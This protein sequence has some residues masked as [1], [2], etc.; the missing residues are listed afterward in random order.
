[1]KIYSYCVIAFI[2]FINASAS[3]EE[4]YR[5]DHYYRPSLTS[6][7][8][9][10][11]LGGMSYVVFETSYKSFEN[12]NILGHA[13]CDLGL[14]VGYKMILDGT[15]EL[16]HWGYHRFQNQRYRTDNLKKLTLH[17]KR[18]SEDIRPLKIQYQ[19]EFT[20]NKTIN[21]TR[22]LTSLPFVLNFLAQSL[23][24][25]Y[26]FMKYGSSLEQFIIDNPS[27]ELTFAGHHPILLHSFTC[28]NIL[29]VAYNLHELYKSYKQEEIQQGDRPFMG[30]MSGL[31]KIFA[32][33]QVFDYYP[34][35][36]ILTLLDPATS[37]IYTVTTGSAFGEYIH[38]TLVFYGTYQFCSN[39]FEMVK[40]AKNFI[41]G[42][43]NILIEDMQPSI[44]STSLQTPQR[45]TTRTNRL[46]RKSRQKLPPPSEE[47]YHT[48]PLEITPLGQTPSDNP[49]LKT[50]KKTRNPADPSKINLYKNPVKE[51]QAPDI[52]NLAARGVNPTKR[53]ETLHTVNELRKFNAVKE[54]YINALLSE[55]CHLLNGTI[56]RIDGNEFAIVF[57]RGLQKISIKYEAPH[58]TDNSNYQ[59]YKLKRVLNAIETSH[60][61]D[62][63]EGSIHKY[64]KKN[65][66][67]R[68]YQ[69]PNNLLHILWTRPDM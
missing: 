55:T 15:F 64:M 20:W 68:F 56:N 47:G 48:Y 49:K 5:N 17:K 69:I 58:G 27:V 14:S 24:N 51:T 39:S 46:P 29:S 59:G 21:I 23:K 42:Q 37:Q 30:V 40:N 4:K 6:A 16:L 44:S 41:L 54:T 62:W 67:D 13:A 18:S 60:M 19:D 26:L 25:E 63:D 65:S 45:K 28:L 2:F 61:Y 43:T 31:S 66:I 38:D 12:Q 33:P 50:K 7:C 1:M 22:S 8:Q 36:Q 34:A 10:I 52:V 32:G 57:Y 9:K 11:V 3:C 53:K 35:R